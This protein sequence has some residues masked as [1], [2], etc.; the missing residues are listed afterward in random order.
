MQSP[1]HA[2]VIHSPHSGR[3]TQLSEALTYLQQV[4]VEVSNSISIAE[5]DNLPAQGAT[6]REQGIDIAI[7][8]GGDGIVGGVITHIA[9][10]GP[11]LGIMPL[12][13]ANDIAR[14]LR[15]PQN[16][17]QAAEVIALGHEQAIDI[18]MA[19]PAEQ[20]LHQASLTQHGPVPYYVAL[21]KHAFFAH[22]LTAGL[23]VQFERIATNIATRK[24]I[25]RLT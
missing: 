17:H 23:N 25:G 5:L 11:P 3:S 24:P 21:K 9:A 18:G 8:A 1:Q 14:S 7:A 10:S 12:G 19:Q 16:L 4:S 20:A 22:V 2:I 6:W 15:I 13:T